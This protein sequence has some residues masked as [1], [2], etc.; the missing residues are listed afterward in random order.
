MAA[1]AA[2]RMV[3]TNLLGPFFVSREAAKLMRKGR[4]GRIIN[5]GSMAARLE[6]VGDSMYAA[7][8]AGLTTMGNVMAKEFSSFNITVNTLAISAIETDMLN[9]LPRDKVRAVVDTLPAPGFANPEDILNIIDFF[10]S[11]RSSGVTAQTLFL[12]GVN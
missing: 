5:I 7:C 10:V 8:K 2:E 9:Q 12:G 11:D 1:E 3:E 4:W 6:P